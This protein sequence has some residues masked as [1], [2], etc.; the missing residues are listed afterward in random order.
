MGEISFEQE[1]ST[2]TKYII[3][4]CDNEVTPETGIPDA[5]RGAQTWTLYS[6]QLIEVCNPIH[7]EI[8]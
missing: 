7:T 6:A 4:M 5:V 3:S 1:V 2:M 8:T